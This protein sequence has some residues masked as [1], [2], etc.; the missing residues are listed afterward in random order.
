MGMLWCRGE[1]GDVYEHCHE[2]N[3]SY[4]EI[5]GTFE[6]DD[7]RGVKSHRGAWRAEVLQAE[8]FYGGCC[9]GEIHG[10]ESWS[11]NGSAGRDTVWVL[12]GEPGVYQEEVSVL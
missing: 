12:G 5:L 10:G 4:G 8:F 1:C 7:C 3:A 11:P 6:P 9:C 2:G